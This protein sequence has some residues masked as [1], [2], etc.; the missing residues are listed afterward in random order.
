MATHEK[1]NIRF[2]ERTFIIVALVHAL[3]YNPYQ[4]IMLIYRLIRNYVRLKKKS[5]GYV[6][7]NARTLTPGE[8]NSFFKLII[9]YPVKS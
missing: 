8:I 5:D 6:P 7:K 2:R 4:P 9:E 1:G 3:K